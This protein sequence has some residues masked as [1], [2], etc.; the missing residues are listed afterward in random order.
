M[1]GID[2]PSYGHKIGK[3]LIHLMEWAIPRLV[4]GG[5]QGIHRPCYGSTGLVVVVLA[6]LNSS[7]FPRTTSSPVHKSQPVNL[8]RP[9]PSV[10]HM[11]K[12]SWILSLRSLLKN[13]MQPTNPN[14]VNSTLLYNKLFEQSTFFPSYR[15]SALETVE[16]GRGWSAKCGV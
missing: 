14:A 5:F 11:L 3:M 16:C 13:R 2:P 6:E 10:I 15:T 9:T 8:V 12:S 1:G 4:S 7:H